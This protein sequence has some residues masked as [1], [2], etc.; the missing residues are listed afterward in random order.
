MALSAS[1]TRPA[2]S[3]APSSL[4]RAVPARLSGMTLAVKTE[5]AR[6]TSSVVAASAN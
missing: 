5:W 4:D 1:E 2:A 3:S 6:P